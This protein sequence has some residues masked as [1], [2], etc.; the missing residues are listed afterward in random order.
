MTLKVISFFSN[1][2]FREEDLINYFLP[3]YVWEE[4][5]F[6]Y[7]LH[8]ILTKWHFAL[9]I[10]EPGWS[11]TLRDINLHIPMDMQPSKLLLNS[12][13]NACC[14]FTSFKQ[15]FGRISFNHGNSPS[16]KSITLWAN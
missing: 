13:K 4:G 12:Y 3:K 5:L 1:Y 2:M 7:L 14:C 6:N 15:C 16:M 8:K 9:T 11:N 10:M